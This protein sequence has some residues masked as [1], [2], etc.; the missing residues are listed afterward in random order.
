MWPRVT[1]GTFRFTSG[2]NPFEDNMPFTAGGETYVLQYNAGTGGNDV[3][4]TTVVPHAG[5]RRA[6]PRRLP[7]L[8]RRWRRG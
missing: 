4:L 3:G 6:I 2:G 7:L 1:S 5:N 8:A